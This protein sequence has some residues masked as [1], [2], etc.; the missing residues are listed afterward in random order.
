MQD[1]AVGEHVGE[2]GAE[3]GQ[4]VVRVT[5]IQQDSQSEGKKQDD[6]KQSQ[7]EEGESNEKDEKGFLATTIFGIFSS[8]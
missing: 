8:Y 5:E 6:E 1:V 7:S 4:V 3:M 2:K